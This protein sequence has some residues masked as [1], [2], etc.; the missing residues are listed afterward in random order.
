MFGKV[1]SAA[2]L[3]AVCGAAP[4]LADLASPAEL[5]PPSFK[6]QQYVDSRGCVFLRAGYG[7]QVTWVPRVT[8]DRKQLCGYGASGPVEV[9]APEP[10]AKPAPKVETA[11]APEVKTA[12]KATAPKTAAKP[13]PAPAPTVVSTPAPKVT[14]PA[15]ATEVAATGGV[16][17]AAPKGGDGYRLACPAETPVAERFEVHGG[18]SKVLCTR[19]DGTLDHATFPKLVAGDLSGQAIGYDAWTA[20][21]GAGRTGE[22]PGGTVYAT[23]DDG[24]GTRKSTK[25][26]KYPK[27]EPPPGYKLAW[28]DDRLNPNR[29]KQTVEGFLAMDEIW[30]RTAPAELREDSTIKRKPVTIIVRHRDGSSSQHDGYVLSSKGGKKVV[31]I[32]GS[33]EVLVSKSTKSVAPEAAPK[34][35]TPAEPAAS[36]R[37]LVQVGTFG[38]AS[39]AEGVA[40]RLKGLGLPVA[41][42]KLKGGALTVVYAGP[43][44]SAAEAKQALSAARGLGFGDARIVQ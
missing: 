27:V 15:T 29:G 43:F 22:A 11:A 20:A 30:T 23:G 38:V 16:V 14:R 8:R 39:N 24:Y 25:S 9:A 3:A 18:G 40:G 2:V 31:Q 10:V 41:R 19:G 42:G 5:P 35:K 21:N 26:A 32:K 28:D 4:A 44:A 36:G 37:F 7:G 12:P 34:V 6:G 1:L 17:V 33:D 13:S